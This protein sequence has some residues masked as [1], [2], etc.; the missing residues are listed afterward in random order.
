MR[1]VLRKA[2]R[3]CPR[4]S[5]SGR[6]VGRGALYHLC[7]CCPA[8]SVVFKGVS[9][10]LGSFGVKKACLTQ[11]KEKD[12]PP[13]GCESPRSQRQTLGEHALSRETEQRGHG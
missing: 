1:K 6:L 12:T 9:C 2:S 10:V 7:G 4:L 3:A 11:A 5:P 13:R 8:L